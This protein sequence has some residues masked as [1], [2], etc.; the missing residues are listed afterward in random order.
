MSEYTEVAGI[1]YRSP[2]RIH[3]KHEKIYQFNIIIVV[4]CTTI[5]CHVKLK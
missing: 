2:M 5:Y 3:E 1:P 4:P